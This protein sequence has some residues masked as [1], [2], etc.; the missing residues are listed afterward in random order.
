MAMVLLMVMVGYIKWEIRLVDCDQTD[1]NIRCGLHRICNHMYTECPVQACKMER[2][3]ANRREPHHS[4][5]FSC[6]YFILHSSLII[7]TRI[8]IWSAC[9]TQMLVHIYSNVHFVWWVSERA[10]DR[11]K[12]RIVWLSV[13][14]AYART[15]DRPTDRPAEQPI[16]C[17][18]RS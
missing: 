6:F 3:R 9:V 4:Y 18:A 7:S 5:G 11:K 17:G 15:T 12:E 13:W 8:T 14:S 2:T 1:V 10:S 16:E